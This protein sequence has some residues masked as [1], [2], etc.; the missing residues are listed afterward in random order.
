MD[1]TQEKVMP[2]K[3]PKEQHAGA[4][5]E[6]HPEQDIALGR[7]VLHALGQAGPLYRVEVHRLWKEHYRVNVLVSAGT[8]L[9]R[10]ARSYFLVTDGDNNVLACT[11]ALTQ[12]DGQAGN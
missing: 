1:R 4:R 6:G 10:I 7:H 9:V 2:A 12:L 5:P 11:P 3:R 8:A